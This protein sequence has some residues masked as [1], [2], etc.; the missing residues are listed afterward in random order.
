M[1]I[2]RAFS[3]MN[4]KRIMEDK[5][6]NKATLISNAQELQ[7]LRT[8]PDGCYMLV[9][10]I[11]LEGAAWVPVDFRGTLAGNF[12]T[13][14]NVTVAAGN[15][16]A[17]FFGTNEGTVWELKLEN[18]TVTAAAGNVGAVAAENY[19]DISAVRV[20]G[21]KLTLRCAEGESNA[22][23]VAG[24]NCG[25]LRNCTAEVEMTVEAKGGRVWA[26]GMVGCTRGGV[27]ETLEN[28]GDIT[29]TG[30]HIR[31]GLFAGR[32]SNTKLMALK[33]SSEMNLLNG[34]LY[35]DRCGEEGER[36][37]F[38]GCIWRDNRNSDRLLKPE[39]LAL[40]TK[41]ERHMHLMGS[42][43]W[44][45]S[46]RLN[47][48]CSCGG[49]VHDQQF[50]P[51]ETYYGVPYTHKHNS[52]EQFLD[53]FR[54]D[55]SLQPWLKDEGWDGFDLHMGCDCSGGVYWAWSRVS[56]D[57]QYRWTGNMR[58]CEQN[59][60]IAVG[61]YTWDEDDDTRQIKQK[62][63]PDK[64]AECVALMHKGD[65]F[66][67]VVKSGHVRMCAGNPVIYRAPDGTVDFMSSYVYTHEQGDGLYPRNRHLHSSWL[68]DH[69]YNLKQLIADDYIPV[70]TPVL[71]QGHAP[72]ARVTYSGE[73]RVNTGV[74]ASNYRII[75][76]TVRVC[77]RDGE[78]VWEKT[79]YTAHNSWGQQGNDYLPRTTVRE[80]DLDEYN[81]YWASCRLTRGE[82]YTYQ[83][84]ALLGTG[85]TYEAARFDF[86]A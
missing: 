14:R 58:P 83:V 80:V 11:D 65:V 3:A 85:D 82:T 41:A 60:V 77:G 75:R 38:D 76:T 23:A 8:A 78:P 57:L 22:G 12:H 27:L 19:G 16:K 72:E 61:D 62:N 69:R 9:A 45:P 52:F 21:G 66:L 59:G 42:Y 63:T 46:R 86:T 35:R 54:E 73:N 36:V 32:A 44:S 70:T 31:A 50:L 67:R 6:M 26:G 68:T 30:E 56:P 79:L 64:I 84:S 49:T 37:I 28:F 47:Y 2:C 55:G 17:G 71:A 40:R 74:V 7:L 33:F 48:V 13:I 1:Q 20:T 25:M 5:K 51:G 10:D 81:L 24:V 15:G 4:R 39:N 53:C 18:V 43:A 34:Q 29:L